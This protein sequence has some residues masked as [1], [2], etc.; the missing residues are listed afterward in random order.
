[1]VCSLPVAGA[2]TAPH[3]FKYYFLTIYFID[4]KVISMAG[5]T[6][7]DVAL[8]A[9]LRAGRAVYGSAIRLALAQIGCDDM[10]RNGIYVIGAIARTG[11][12]LSEIIVA[13]GMSKQAAGQLVETLVIRGYLDRVVDT[14]DRRRLTV[15]LTARG[16][17]VAATS[18]VAI[19]RIDAKLEKLLGTKFVAHTRATLIALAELGEER[20]ED[21]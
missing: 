17:A 7:P 15:S 2:P 13:L 19:D 5:K 11:A 8:P 9:L 20:H 16:R 14:E 12:A 3:V 18:R 4:Y 6:L 1:M 10:P 21:E